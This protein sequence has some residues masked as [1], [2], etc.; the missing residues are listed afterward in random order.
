MSTT[1]RSKFASRPAARAASSTCFWSACTSRRDG[2]S[3]SG[4]S[5]SPARRAAATAACHFAGSPS[6]SASAWPRSSVTSRSA[7]SSRAAWSRLCCQ[8]TA[9]PGAADGHQRQHG[10]GQRQRQFTPF[11]LLLGPRIGLHPSQLGRPEPLLHAAEVGGHPRGHGTGVARPVLRLR[12]QAIPR[13]GDQ[14]GLRPAGVEPGQGVGRVAPHRLAEHLRR[15]PPGVGRLAGEDLAEDRTQAEDIGP[16]VDVLDLTPGLL[17]RHVGRRPQHAAG[18]R[19][20]DRPSRCVRSGSRSPRSMG[21]FGGGDLNFDRTVPGLIKATLADEP[22]VIR[23]DGEFVR[24]FLYVKDAA[25]SYLT[26][27]ERLAEDE[28]IS[29]EAFNFSLGERLTVLEIVH[30]MLRIMG[31]SDLK[32]IIQNIVTTEVREQYLDATKARE[33]LG[34]RPQYGMK[35]AISET[36]DWYRE[37]FAEERRQFSSRP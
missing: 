33:R 37:H 3:I 6:G 26:L 2:P 14:L 24:D 36:V 23:S 19:V 34:W 30:M 7:S 17:G 29:G 32:P 15:A 13:Q 18:L 12:G 16:A 31:R 5:K 8:Y 1:A 9:A 21:V 20:V 10:G 4:P 35:E 22:F 25:Q 11:P 28:S 27:G